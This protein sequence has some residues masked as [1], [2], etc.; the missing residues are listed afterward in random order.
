[1]PQR[2]WLAKAK[3]IHDLGP[4]YTTPLGH[5]PWEEKREKLFDAKWR[6]WL[7]RPLPV[8]PAFQPYFGS[9]MHDSQ[10]LGIEREERVL[11]VRLD[12][13]NA[14][15]FAIG[16]ADVLEVPR[17]DARW[18]VDLLLA[19]PIYVRAARYDA[20]GALRYADPYEV[21][22]GNWQTG[23][24]FLYDWFFEE[25]DRLQWIAELQAFRRGQDALS[26]N[27]M[28]MVDCSRATALDRRRSTLE[29]AFGLAAGTLWQE[30]LDG[31]DVGDAPYGP[32]SVPTMESFLM[33]RMAAHGLTREDFLLPSMP[34]RPGPNA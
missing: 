25:D 31:V 20:K 7:K 27:K 16:L 22:A 32:W 12:S 14:D 5:E 34:R 19:D 13:I 33:R 3:T 9:K 2:S 21:L 4:H 8:E 10:I 23:D 30:A 28:L 1:M 26:D 15:I 24:R 17:V 18:P 6:A 11:R 29:A